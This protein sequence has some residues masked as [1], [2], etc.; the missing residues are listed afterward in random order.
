[1]GIAPVAAQVVVLSALA[2]AVARVSVAGLVPACVGDCGGDGAVSIADLVAGVGIALDHQPVLHLPGMDASGDGDVSID[3]ADRRGGRG[4]RRVSRHADRADPHRHAAGADPAR[5]RSRRRRKCR[6]P[7][8]RRARRRRRP[9]SCRR[10]ATSA[11]CPARCSSPPSARNLVPGGPAGT[12]DLGFLSLPVGFC[13]HFFANVGNTRQLRFAPGG[14]LFVASPTTVHHR[15]WRRAGRPPS[16]SSPTTTPTASPT[17]PITFLD[18]PAADARACSSPTAISTTRTARASCAC[19]TRA[20]RAHADRRRARRVANINHYIS[21]AAL[22]E[23]AR[24]RR[25]R[26]HLRRQRRRRGRAVTAAAPVPRRHPRARRHAGRGRWRKGFRNPIARALPARPQPLLRHRAGARLL[27]R[28]WAGARSWCRSATATTGASPAAR[29]TDRPV[30]RHP[31]GAGLLRRRRP[32]SAPSSSATRPFDLDF[33]TG[34]WPEPWN[35]RVYVPLHG[36]FGTWEG[37][38]VVGIELD[39]DHRR[40]PARL[41]SARHADA[42]PWRDFATGWDDGTR[43]AR[44]SRRSSPFAADGRL[45]LGNDNTGDIIWIAPMS[46]AAPPQ[47]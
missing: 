33:E 3:G 19:R 22:A 24:R 26:H 36:V 6:P 16:S 47:P 28:P 25:R 45:F 27:R 2:L 14:E 8:Y 37:A 17:P 30:R 11:T 35:H 10:R 42:A 32:R 18:Q 40:R 15:R 39:H 4:A 46:L 5:R 12:P 38:R 13:A 44:P 9:P 29:R 23:A 20:G 41:G 43:V 1:M 7:P 31:P 21:I 34:K